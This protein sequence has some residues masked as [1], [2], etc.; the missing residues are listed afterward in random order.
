MGGN[1]KA[2]V[3]GNHY[4]VA[5]GSPDALHGEGFRGGLVVGGDGVMAHNE[6]VLDGAFL[7]DEQFAGEGEGR[8]VHVVPLVSAGN[9]DK[10]VA[11]HFSQDIPHNGVHIGVSQFGV[12]FIGIFHYADVRIQAAVAHEY[13]GLFH[14][15]HMESVKVHNFHI[16]VGAGE[17]DYGRQGQ[18]Q[19]LFH[20]L[21]SDN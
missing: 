18:G 17:Q 21:T 19:Y 9:M 5:F 7:G 6:Q 20:R 16:R 11:V 1:P 12:G 4:S 15:K 3:I 10:F 2:D 14:G 8:A 13:V